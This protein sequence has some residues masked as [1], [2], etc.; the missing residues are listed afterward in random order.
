M[1]CDDIDVEEAVES[2][3]YTLTIG[4]VFAAVGALVMA[5][6]VGITACA[7]STAFDK[8][9][10]HTIRSAAKTHVFGWGA[11]GILSGAVWHTEAWE[12]LQ[13]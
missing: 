12:V 13:S 2:A 9:C 11:V 1:N 6:D 10:S 3:A 4:A 5:Q 8:G 7:S